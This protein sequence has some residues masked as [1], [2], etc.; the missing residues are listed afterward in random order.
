MQEHYRTGFYTAPASAESRKLSI[1][2]TSINIW[3]LC[4][5]CKRLPASCRW[6]HTHTHGYIR[7]KPRTYTHTHTHTHKHTHTHRHTVTHTY[8]HTHTNAYKRTKPRTHTHTQRD[9]V[10]NLSKLIHYNPLCCFHIIICTPY[11]SHAQIFYPTH[12]DTTN[13]EPCSHTF[14]PHTLVT[15]QP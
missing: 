11:F 5:F 7:T 15:T 9:N 4:C 3:H 2:L 14:W 10:C 12:T 13:R 6:Q 8:T 1:K